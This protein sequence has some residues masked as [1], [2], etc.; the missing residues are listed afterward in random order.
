MKSAVA[1]VLWFT[2]LSGSG[3]TTISE[4]LK[5]N[6]INKNKKVL[7]IDGDSIRTTTNKKLGF[8]EGDIK[9]NNINIAKLVVENQN[10]FDFIII[11]VISPYRKHR[12]LVR[13]IISFN[14]NEIYIKCT[15]NKCIERD[16]KGLYKKAIKG[17]ISN[18]LFY[19]LI[20]CYYLVE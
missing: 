9:I 17:E 16:V 7:S 3:K 1:T 8:S 18:M 13:D 20:V 4:S 19:D 10:K 15:I 2:G 11:S 6:L 14:F 12:A 5:K